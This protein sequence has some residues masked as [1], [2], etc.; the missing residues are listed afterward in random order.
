MSI[1]IKKLERFPTN[2]TYTVNM[3]LANIT[4]EQLAVF[5]AILNKLEEESVS[6]EKYKVMND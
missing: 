5:E 4:K 2:N 1:D 3:R 6:I